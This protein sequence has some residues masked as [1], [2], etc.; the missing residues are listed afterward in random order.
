LFVLQEWA[1]RF[2]PKRNKAIFTQEFS[3]GESSY[4]LCFSQTI[5]YSHYGSYLMRM[6]ETNC[7]RKPGIIDIR[8]KK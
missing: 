4:S 1:K 5:F 8:S 7:G 6:K 2:G 3:S